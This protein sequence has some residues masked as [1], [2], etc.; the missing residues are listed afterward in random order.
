MKYVKVGHCWFEEKFP[1]RDIWSHHCRKVHF[2]SVQVEYNSV[3]GLFQFVGELIWFLL[4]NLAS[5]YAFNSLLLQHITDCEY[6]LVT[7]S[8]SPLDYL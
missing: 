4:T 7:Y 3:I 1:Q 8:R 2:S 5:K 6:V